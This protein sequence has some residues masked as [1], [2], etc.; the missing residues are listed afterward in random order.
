MTTDCIESGAAAEPSAK[1]ADL[2]LLFGADLDLARQALQLIWNGTGTI[3]PQLAHWGLN[4][5]LAVQIEQILAAPQ[6]GV[7]ESLRRKLRFR[8]SRL[9][10]GRQ[11][12]ALILS[13][14]ALAWIN[15]V[16]EAPNRQPL[17]LVLDGGIGDHLEN[18]SLLLPWARQQGAT[19]Q[20]SC[21]EPI[22]VA[23]LQRLL[24]Q[25]AG[26]T[27]Q[28]QIPA[29]Q[30]RLPAMALRVALQQQIPLESAVWIHGAP[31]HQPKRLV[32]C[33]RA[34]GRDDRLSI[35][36]RSLPYGLVQGFYQHLLSQGWQAEQIVD[37]TA[38]KD[39]ER[40]SLQSLGIR[41]HNPAEGDVQDLATLVAGA[42]VIS[43]DT[44]LVHLCAAMGQ[45]VQLL[46]PLFADE[47][48]AELLRPGH[49]YAR[50][51]QVWRQRRYGD[52]AEVLSR[53]ARS[54][55]ARSCR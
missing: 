6:H 11:D 7:S 31:S 9:A 4:L 39:W 28:T 45:A 38:W 23:Q 22:R 46:L 35:H 24:T 53:L 55:A 30:V 12:L 16:L 5:G 18:L 47:R 13:P 27:L 44:A 10:G 19:L 52:W 40:S 43:I 33:W 36:L 20:L 42:Q 50:W 48:W 3:D 25:H 37:I 32:C 41:Q 51:V 26:V 2:S 8:L 34:A 21:A 29:G 1:L 17:P 14:E 15:A 54:E 49:S